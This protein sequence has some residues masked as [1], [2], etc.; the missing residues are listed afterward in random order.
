M[1][2]FF[3]CCYDIKQIYQTEIKVP[4]KTSGGCLSTGIYVC[5]YVCM[6]VCMY[7]D[8]SELQNYLDDEH[9][10]LLTR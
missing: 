8:V 5:T 2:I 4:A 6:Y 1:M 9:K 10:E 7:M 3:R